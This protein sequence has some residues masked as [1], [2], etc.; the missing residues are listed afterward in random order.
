MFWRRFVFLNM[1]VSSFFIFS[2]FVAHV[3]KR[4]FCLTWKFT[5]QRLWCLESSVT[6]THTRQS[7][8]QSF[9]DCHRFCWLRQTYCELKHLCWQILFRPKPCLSVQCC[10]TDTACWM[11]F[12]PHCKGEWKTKCSRR[13]NLWIP[14]GYWFSIN[15]TALLC[16]SGS[17][18]NVMAEN[19]F[20]MRS[21]RNSWVIVCS[22]V[23]NEYPVIVP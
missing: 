10:S 21:H 4:T 8:I 13:M 7:C 3:K 17:R 5:H 15:C 18:K 1:F 6:Q 12:K 19:C 11:F 22:M 2:L 14:L 20:I 9:W 16:L 23:S